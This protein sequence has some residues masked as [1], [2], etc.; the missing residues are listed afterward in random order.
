MKSKED[1]VRKTQWDDSLFPNHLKALKNENRVVL[2]PYNLAPTHLAVPYLDPPNWVHYIYWPPDCFQASILFCVWILLVIVLSIPL[3]I[4]LLFTLQVSNTEHFYSTALNELR[5]R[6]TVF[7][8]ISVMNLLLYSSS[9]H[10][11]SQMCAY[12]YHCLPLLHS[13]E[14]HVT[15][16]SPLFSYLLF[17]HCIASNEFNKCLWKEGCPLVTYY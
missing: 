1:L 13:M 8:D 17:Q 11:I 7:T 12:W 14:K 5:D 3:T 16:Y 9:C 4:Y 6:T 10:T 15:F 2:A